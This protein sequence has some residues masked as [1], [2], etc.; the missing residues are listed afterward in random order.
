MGRGG[1]ETAQKWPGWWVERPAPRTLDL[2]GE[3]QGPQAHKQTGW[4]LAGLL[5]P[6]GRNREAAAGTR[7]SQPRPVQVT[8]RWGQCEPLQCSLSAP[9]GHSPA[10]HRMPWGLGFSET[11]LNWGQSIS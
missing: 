7:M 3:K 1:R 10:E 6:T 5:G 9:A 4:V 11:P 8:A 2:T